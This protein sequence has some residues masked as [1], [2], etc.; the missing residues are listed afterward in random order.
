MY[1]GASESFL[2]SPLSGKE[3]SGS[4]GIALDLGNGWSADLSGLHSGSK[5]V[6]HRDQLTDQGFREI[7][8]ELDYDRRT[9]LSSLSAVLNG[10]VSSIGR[11]TPRAALG[12][13][14]REEAN[15]TFSLLRSIT[16]PPGTT[17]VSATVSDLDRTVRSVFGE[18]RVP[19]VEN[20][21]P[22]L[23]RLELSFGA[24]QDWYSDVG[25]TLNWNYG[26]IWQLSADWILRGNYATAFHAPSLVNLEPAAFGELR[27]IA[28]PANGANTMSPVLFVGGRLPA[29]PEEASSWSAS[30]D[31]APSFAPWAN[32]SLSYISIEYQNRIGS[33]MTSSELPLALVRETRFPSLINRSPSV[34]DLE[35][36]FAQRTT[37]TITNAQAFPA[38]D[39]TTGAAGLLGAIPNLILIDR[40]AQNIAIETY[41]GID[42]KLDTN[43]D[44]EIGR[45]TFGVNATYLLER[46]SAFTPTSEP[47][48]QLN[49]IGRPVDLR[50]RGNSGW[51]R[52]PWSAFVYLNYADS[53]PNNFSTPV[54]KVGSWTTA[55][56][57][58]RFNG[59]RGVDGGWLRDIDM[60]LNVSNLFNEDPPSIELVRGASGLSYDPANANPTGRFVTMSVTKRW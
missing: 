33:P 53:Y 58:L 59:A 44:T 48:S 21:R 25:D 11:V 43:F 1:A 39:P 2:V 28:D 37:E 56:V 29:L 34:S 41:R 38:W 14:V 10:P 24:R 8:G 3:H 50:L 4:A 18:L 7:V 27:S 31:Y 23:E 49:E 46:G 20:G 12:T 17:N 47:F 15:K 42:L 9:T 16:T 54:S 35:N 52:G 6:I 22:G 45:L 40:R 13:E 5:R 36:F 26:L 19:F 51:T 55:D 30:L 60:S 57:T 32:L